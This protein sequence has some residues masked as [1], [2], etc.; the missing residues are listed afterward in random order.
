MVPD[1]ILSMLVKKIHRTHH[2]SSFPDPVTCRKTQ[3]LQNVEKEVLMTIANGKKGSEEAE[4]GE[5]ESEAVTCR[6]GHMDL[7]RDFAHGLLLKAKF[8]PRPYSMWHH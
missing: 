2:L 7:Q 5:D 1:L 8:S 4:A 6:R 3:R